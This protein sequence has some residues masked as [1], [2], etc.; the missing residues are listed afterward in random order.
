MIDTVLAVAK[1]LGKS[2]AQVALN[3]ASAAAGRHRRRSSARATSTQLEDNIGAT[4]W[5]LGE[6]ADAEAD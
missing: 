6:E 2:P 4:G 5:K 3:W 1:D